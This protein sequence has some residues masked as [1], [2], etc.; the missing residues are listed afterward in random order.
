MKSRVLAT[1]ALV[2]FGTGCG[3]LLGGNARSP[4]PDM[5]KV[6]L[7]EFEAAMGVDAPVDL[8]TDADVK[9][10]VEARKK[11]WAC[12]GDV[13]VGEAHAWK[14]FARDY[15]EAKLTTSK[16]E[17]SAAEMRA[18]CETRFI[19]FELATVTAC[20]VRQVSV[21]S[22]AT[23]AGWTDPTISSPKRGWYFTP[24]TE[25]PA[26]KGP[27]EVEAIRPQILS[28]CGDGTGSLLMPSQWGTSS[29]ADKRVVIVECRRERGA[30]SDWLGGDPSLK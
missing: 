27:K 3:A 22:R 15:P 13:P 28:A 21:E 5:A 30:F 7:A 12:G 24:C 26:A 8:K 23:P 25:A 11:L 29:D 10:R 6:M 16:G 2:L 17:L 20:G 1:I 18:Q 4:D 14:T 19:E 9:S